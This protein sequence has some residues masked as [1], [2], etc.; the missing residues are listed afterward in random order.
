MVFELGR[1]P[2]QLMHS[3][4]EL[5]GATH[6]RTRHDIP[7]TI[8]ERA[9]RPLKRS[10]LQRILLVTDGTVTEILEAYSG[11]SMR[12]VK[13]LEEVTTIEDTLPGLDLRAG[14]QVLR[15]QI[16]LQGKMTL[17]NFLYADS[18]IA[19]DRLDDS[20]RRALLES[21]KPIGFLIQE[22]RMETF[23]E[24]LGCGRELAGPIAHHFHIDP[25]DG[26]IW[27]TY[28]VFFRGEPIMQITEKFPESHFVD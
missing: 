23:R 18:Y 9:V 14:E 3:I 21:H 27:R 16:V 19:L 2:D 5:N 12:L 13:L 26:M 6:A 10:P 8:V 11:E 1:E 25:A 7:L 20:L 24:I 17:G 22:Q 4:V 28:R 15:R